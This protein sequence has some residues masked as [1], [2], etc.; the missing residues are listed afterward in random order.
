M[1]VDGG[2]VEG[3]GI[4]GGDDTILGGEITITTNV[5]TSVIRPSFK[6]IAILY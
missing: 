5:N 4:S 1:K 6:V 3:G 2:G